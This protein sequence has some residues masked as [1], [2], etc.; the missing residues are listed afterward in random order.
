MAKAEEV[1]CVREGVFVNKVGSKG[2]LWARF[3]NPEKITSVRGLGKSRLDITYLANV[4]WNFATD[5]NRDGALF[6]S[7][8]SPVCREKT[9]ARNWGAVLRVNSGGGSLKVV[10]LRGRISQPTP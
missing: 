5:G 1:P 3:A 8:D 6:T 7:F 9:N 4:S 2:C 10:E